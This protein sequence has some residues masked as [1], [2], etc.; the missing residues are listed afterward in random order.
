MRHLTFVVG[1]AWLALAGVAAAQDGAGTVDQAASAAPD[2]PASAAPDQPA[3]AAPDQPAP[4]ENSAE[5]P[6]DGA[7]STSADQAAPQG[8]A[9]DVEEL[10]QRIRIL[11]RRNELADE[12]AADKAKTA[13]AAAANKDGFSFKSA[14]GNFQ[15]KFRGL[16]QLDARFF[17]EDE[18]RPAVD[19]F[20][21]RR[22][23]P[24]LEGTVFKLF[25]FRFT[26]D[27][28]G[29][30]TV[31]Q[32][33]YVDARF[34][35]AARLRVG[36]FK[37]P[38]GLER[39]QSASDLLF[40]ERGL[41]TNLVPNRDLGVQL[42]G[43]LAEARVN[44][45]LGVFNG[46][47]DGAS[48]DVDSDDGKDVAARVF[49]TPWPKADSAALK[50]FGFGVAFSTGNPEGTPTATGL[51]GYRTGGQATF[52]SYRSDGTP[53][54]TTVAAGT[55]QRFSPQLTWY[56]G[57]FGLLAEYVSS[58]QE[59][60]RGAVRDELE[61]TAWQASGSFVLS[62]GEPSYRGVNPRHPFDLAAGTWGAFELAARYNVLEVDEAAFPVFANPASAAS[63]A[64][65]WAVGLNWYLTRGLRFMLDYEQTSFTGGAAT[66]DREDEKVLLNRFQISF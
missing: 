46:V 5:T 44:Y 39:L 20:L 61:N 52:F 65:A 29:G 30:T 6:A 24:I 56:A 19:T 47:P 4:Q 34:H 1:L 22:V 59:V 45:A 3:T 40:V 37:A 28:G 31:L 18:Q 38:V 32:D 25:D 23:R 41:P 8:A 54:G 13:T 50:G 11:E 66:G 43:D 2:Q 12:Q 51:T 57:R 64:E 26:P 48:A 33:A 35:P 10:E 62:G 58:S 9:P 15:V 60:A 49:F 21:L 36:K 63:R 17:A 53:A 55:R 14:D 42:F 7:Q 27:F 16:I